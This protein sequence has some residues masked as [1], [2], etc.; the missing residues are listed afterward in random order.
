MGKVLYSAF[1]MYYLIQTLAGTWDRY[2]HNAYYIKEKTEIQR[3]KTL[4]C[5]DLSHGAV[6]QGVNEHSFLIWFSL[7]KY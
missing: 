5:L 3:A 1:H 4:F 6:F 2:H 7:I